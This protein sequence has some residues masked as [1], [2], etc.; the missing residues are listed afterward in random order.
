MLACY[1]GDSDDGDSDGD[2]SDDGDS[3]DGDSNDGDSDD[4][5]CYK[6]WIRYPQQPHLTGLREDARS[7]PTAG[8]DHTM[9]VMVMVMVILTMMVMVELQAACLGHHHTDCAKTC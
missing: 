6:C 8:S 9:M 2:D 7:P 3:D 1:D 5:D 4:G